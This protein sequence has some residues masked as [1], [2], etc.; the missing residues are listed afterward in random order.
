MGLISFIVFLEFF[1]IDIAANLSQSSFVAEDHGTCF[2]G[3][4]S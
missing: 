4:L 3:E 2:L 1:M